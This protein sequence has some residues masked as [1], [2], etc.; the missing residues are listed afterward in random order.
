MFFQYSFHHWSSP[1]KPTWAGELDQFAML[2]MFLKDVAEQMQHVN[3]SK[4]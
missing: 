3:Q 4:K 1:N 2:K